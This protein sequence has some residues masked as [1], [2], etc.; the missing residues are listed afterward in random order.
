MNF[1][2]N[3]NREFEPDDLEL[4]RDALLVGL[5]FKATQSFENCR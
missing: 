2:N 1:Q 4:I 5:P 3:G